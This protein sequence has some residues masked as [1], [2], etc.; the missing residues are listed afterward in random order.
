MKSLHRT[1]ILALAWALSVIA[2]PS[3]ATALEVTFDSAA[4]RAVLQAVESPML[5]RDEALRIASLPGNQG[6]IRKHRSYGLKVTDDSFADALLAA[7]TDS[8]PQE[9]VARLFGFN[10][11][12]ARAKR[13]SEL[14]D[15]IERDRTGFESWVV[16]RVRQFTPHGS[17][18]SLAGYLIVGGPNGGFAFNEPEFFLNLDYFNEFDAAKVL[19]AHE[20]YHGLQ[21][22]LRTP[23]ERA[24]NSYDAT[25]FKG[26]VQDRQCIELRLL[27]GEL[28]AEGSATY[29]GDPALIPA[30]SG[31]LSE[32]MRK[33]LTDKLQSVK[34]SVT[35]L[36]LSVTGLTAAVPTRYDD[37][38]ALGFSVPE[39]LYTLGYVMAKAVVGHRGDS[40]LAELARM[41]RHAFLRA[42]VDLPQYGK[43]AAH[44][45]L[46]ANT[47]DA[48]KRIERQC[49]RP[50]IRRAVR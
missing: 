27:F 24:L 36:E 11:V 21:E 12:K 9:A 40:A 45:K 39:P 5:T 4:A 2:L 14:L 8:R 43:D 17:A 13:L 35:L 26:T 3:A 28:Y 41:P 18:T 23:A 1:I 25:A 19:M 10:A 34:K 29:V 37:V 50:A 20:L 47:I 15:R 22:A 42:Y 38:Y 6:L 7:A 32:K 46:G 49:L 44:P 31:S 33:E 16:A 48:L 30:D